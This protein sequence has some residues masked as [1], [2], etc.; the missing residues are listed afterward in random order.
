[1]PLFPLRNGHAALAMTPKERDCHAFWTRN[2]NVK[3]FIALIIIFLLDQSQG[4][5]IYKP[6]A[7]E[8]QSMGSGLDIRH[9]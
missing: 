7:E 8:N 6:I 2:D 1:M 5:R 4:I 3:T 9:P